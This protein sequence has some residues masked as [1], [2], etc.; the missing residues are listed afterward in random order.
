MPFTKYP[1]K[2][3]FS[4][5]IT[6]HNIPSQKKKSNTNINL[7]N[8]LT[9]LRNQNQNQNTSEQDIPLIHVHVPQNQYIPLIGYPSPPPPPPP[10]QKLQ[11]YTP[12]KST[13]ASGEVTGGL[14]VVTGGEATTVDNFVIPGFSQ[15]FVCWFRA[16]DPERMTFLNPVWQFWTWFISFHNCFINET[17][18]FKII[19]AK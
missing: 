16:M 1:L 4:S 12:N 6:K 15:R 18:Y 8:R 7:P 11:K 14:G 10:P 19:D 17:L 9:P 3:C 2:C 13:W 5:N